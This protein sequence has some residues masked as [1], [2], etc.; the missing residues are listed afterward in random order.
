MNKQ[1]GEACGGAALAIVDGDRLVFYVHPNHRPEITHFVT[2]SAQ[3]APVT[4]R[5]LQAWG[6]AL[7][8][9][10]PPLAAD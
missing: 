1:T 4:I 8:F 10:V 7:P 3:D 9:P 2:A 6:M 5:L